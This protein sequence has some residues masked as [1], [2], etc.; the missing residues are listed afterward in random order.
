MELK[1]LQAEIPV[2]FKLRAGSVIKKGSQFFEVD[3]IF[4]IR[5]SLATGKKVYEFFGIP[6]KL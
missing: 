5:I 4:S 3:K 6:F 1:V 2:S